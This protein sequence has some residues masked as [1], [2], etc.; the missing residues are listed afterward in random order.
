[1]KF[2]EQLDFSSTEHRQR[3]QEFRQKKEF[4]VPVNQQKTFRLNIQR[5]TNKSYGINPK[6]GPFNKIA[7]ASFY[8]NGADN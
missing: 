5:V 8:T 4:K 1:M 6:A 2:N 7:L 3:I